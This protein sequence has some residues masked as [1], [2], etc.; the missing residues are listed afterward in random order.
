MILEG[1]TLYVFFV[2]CL[3][4]YIKWTVKEAADSRKEDLKRDI[5][6]L[7]SE[8]RKIEEE[9]RSEFSSVKRH[10]IS[11][12]NQNSKQIM[13]LIDDKFIKLKKQINHD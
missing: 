3:V 1:L 8:L 6:N 7:N 9:L 2:L 10:C 12:V 11:S 13:E 4:C 5:I